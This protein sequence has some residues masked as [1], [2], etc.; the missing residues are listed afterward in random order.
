MKCEIKTNSFKGQFWDNFFYGS[1]KDMKPDLVVNLGIYYGHVTYCMAKALDVIG[2]GELE[3]WDLWD[4]YPYTHCEMADAAANL[5]GLPI[6]LRQQDAF[7]AH[8]H[9]IENSVD[10]LFVD[11]SN[12]GDTFKRILTDWYP[13][14]KAD[15]KIMMEGGSKERDQVKWMLQ[16][17]FTPIHPVI[18]ENNEWLMEKYLVT[19]INEWPSLTVFQK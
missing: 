16:Y 18:H 3:G 17:G 8:K 5:D 9:Y 12:N 15:G 6:M 11:L 19:T 7:E 10:L 2:K 4:E 14:M 1:V 13:I